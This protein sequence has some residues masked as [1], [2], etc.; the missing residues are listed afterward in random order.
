MQINPECGGAIGVSG[1]QPVEDEQTALL[2]PPHLAE[3]RSES[4]AGAGIGWPP[5]AVTAISAFVT[6]TGMSS[7]P[8]PLLVLIFTLSQVFRDVYFGGVFQR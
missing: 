6:E 1:V 7:L 5:S 4:G 8:G 2:A 3:H